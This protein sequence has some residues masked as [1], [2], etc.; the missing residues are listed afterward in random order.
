MGHDSIA[1]IISISSLIFSLASP[2]VT[3]VINGHYSIKEKK[4][5]DHSDLTK[6]NNNFYTRHR[7]EVIESYISNA[8]AV[9]YHHNNSAKTDFGKCSTEIYLYIDESEWTL[10][11]EIN[12]GIASS[13]YDNSR[14]S[15][16]KLSKIIAK[17]Y[18]VRTIK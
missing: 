8:G 5:T 2:I 1:L 17:N 6:E 10:I 11:D 3:S 7:A 15:L 4:L 14:E 16:E 13:S 12:G 9:I 18:H